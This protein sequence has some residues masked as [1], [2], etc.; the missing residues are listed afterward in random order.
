MTTS[1]LQLR[2]TAYAYQSKEFVDKYS[3]EALTLMGRLWQDVTGFHSPSYFLPEGSPLPAWLLDAVRGVPTH[4][5]EG[6]WPQ[7]ARYWDPINWPALVAEHPDEIVWDRPEYASMY[8]DLWDWG[9]QEGLNPWFDV[10]LW[11]SADAKIEV[12]VG[13]FGLIEFDQ[14]KEPAPAEHIQSVEAILATHE[15]TDAWSFPDGPTTWQ[16]D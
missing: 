6:G 11:I 12:S 1:L 10:G 16:F 5:I 14:L 13:A 15:F 4:G 7:F 3:A 9:H 2:E 8:K